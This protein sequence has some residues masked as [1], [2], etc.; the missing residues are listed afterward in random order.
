MAHFSLEFNTW[1]IQGYL[2][3]LKLL[4]TPQS[5]NLWNRETSWLEKQAPALAYWN[6]EPW[7]VLSNIFG[8]FS[9][10]VLDTFW[11]SGA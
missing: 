6:T 8:G 5:S 7:E 9:L 10:C 2:K 4:T 11:K 3:D 1:R